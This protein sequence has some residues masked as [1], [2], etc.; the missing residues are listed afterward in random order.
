MKKTEREKER[1]GEGKKMKEKKEKRGQK[2]HC[3]VE[4]HKKTE[5]KKNK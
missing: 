4:D 2:S 5:G 3:D 1:E